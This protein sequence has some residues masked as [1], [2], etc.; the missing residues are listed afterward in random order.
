ML[1][2]FQI[3]M[4]VI[5]GCALLI[6][7]LYARVRRQAAALRAQIARSG[8]Q[9]VRGPDFAHYQTE[10]VVGVWYSGSLALTQE[11]LIFRKIIGG[12]L[13]LPL[14]D[15]RGVTESLWFGGRTRNGRPWL[16]IT[17]TDNSQVGFMVRHHKEW[18]RA[19]WEGIRQPDTHQP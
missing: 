4:L 10:G 15:L 14:A 3:V 2:P 1:A 19:V 12:D 16:I 7:G 11:R 6:A 17:R 18:L 9:L 13:V 5:A 8:E